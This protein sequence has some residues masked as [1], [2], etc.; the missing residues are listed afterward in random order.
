MTGTAGTFAT[1]LLNLIFEGTSIAGIAQNAAAP[2]NECVCLASYCR[3][4]CGN[5][6]HV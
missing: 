2:H 3:S 6:K 4:D 5:A 1:G